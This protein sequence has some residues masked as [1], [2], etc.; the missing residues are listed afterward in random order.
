MKEFILIPF[1]TGLSAGIYCFTC[2]I[3]FVAPIMVSEERSKPENVR[4]VLR[5]ILGR[6]FGYLLFG[7]I[8]G[9]LGERFNLGGLN[10]I[11]NVSLVLMSIL[12]VLHGVGLLKQERFSVCSRLIRYNP[13][14]P[15]FMGF[16]MGVNICP[17]FLISLAYVFT[18]HSV[19]S[20]IMY[21]LIFFIGTSIY[22]LPVFFLGWLNKYKEF[23]IIGRISAVVVGVAFFVYSLYKI[24]KGMSCYATF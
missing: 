21:F 6:F 12:L 2:C 1:L 15:L 23:Q 24:I 10:A 13:Q 19:F 17:P 22:F 18:L 5:F 3:P 16:L 8:M 20:G 11:L 14:L 7:A 4:V 9:Y